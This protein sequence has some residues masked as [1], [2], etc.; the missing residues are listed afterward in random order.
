MILDALCKGH[1][2]IGYDLPAPTRGFHFIAHGMESSSQMGDELDYKGGV[3]FQIRIPR[4]AE[5]MLVK[6]GKPI[7]T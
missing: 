5:C 6:D 7:R 4:L 2:F 1:Y 3:T